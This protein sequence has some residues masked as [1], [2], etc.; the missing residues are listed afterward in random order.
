MCESVDYS[1]RGMR[2]RLQRLYFFIDYPDSI[3]VQSVKH[4][5][6]EIISDYVKTIFHHHEKSIAAI[7]TTLRVFLRFLYLNQFTDEDLSYKVPGQNKYNYPDIPSVWNKEDVIRMLEGIDRG[8]PTGKRDYAILL[9]VVKPGMRA[10]DLKSLMLSNLNWQNKTIE[11]I[12]SRTKA[13]I[14]YQILKDTGWA[15]ID[16]LRNARPKTDSPYLFVR[17]NA[18]YDAFGPN[19]NLYNIIT[20]YSRSAG[21][22]ASKE[23]RHGLHS[24]RHTLAGNLPENG[25]TPPPVISEIPGHINSASMISYLHTTIERLRLCALEPD[26]EAVK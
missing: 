15:L 1:K 22:S 5:T 4:I 19:A 3:K 8:N 12:Q 11:I 9:L 26:R 24:L 13:T 18:P 23:K 14:T 16:Y 7:L 17:M 10:G 20:I 25:G 6:P 2:T 21:I